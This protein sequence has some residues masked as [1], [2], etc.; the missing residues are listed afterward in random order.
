MDTLANEKKRLCLKN[1]QMGRCTNSGRR[2]SLL[3]QAL[4]IDV[5]DSNAM[6]SV[7]RLTS[8]EKFRKSANLFLAGLEM[9]ME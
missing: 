4:G 3:G 5:S 8:W 2:A 7:L 6:T 1:R 9:E